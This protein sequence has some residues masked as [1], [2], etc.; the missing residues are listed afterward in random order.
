M[1]Q[2]E[3][4]EALAIVIMWMAE[5]TRNRIQH[6]HD[7]L[8]DFCLQHQRNY[9]ITQDWTVLKWGFTWIRAVLHNRTPVSHTIK[10]YKNV[11][12]EKNWTPVKKMVWKSRFDYVIQDDSW[13]SF[14]PQTYVPPPAIAQMVVHLLGHHALQV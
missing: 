11:V 14:D 12:D 13:S 6:R 5:G 3:D 4:M 10:I 1:K 9:P 7:L 8:T 2:K